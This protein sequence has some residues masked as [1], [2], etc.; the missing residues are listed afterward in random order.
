VLVLPRADDDQ[1]ALVS[2]ERSRHKSRAAANAT[3]RRANAETKSTLA[4]LVAEDN[5]A[6]ASKR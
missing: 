3:L 2:A 1:R 5:R 6:T 4:A